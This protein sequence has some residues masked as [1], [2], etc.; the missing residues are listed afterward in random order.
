MAGV[1]CWGAGVGSVMGHS[2]GGTVLD[3]AREI[4]EAQGRGLLTNVPSEPGKRF[5]GKPGVGNEKSHGSDSSHEEG[6]GRWE[7][8]GDATPQRSQPWP[9][10]PHRF[11][12]GPLRPRWSP[13]C[14]G[15]LSGRK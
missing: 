4:L 15:L 12:P 9:L 11:L 8:V 7:T 14:S 1:E 5:W 2:R 10:L 13:R 6:A 3:M